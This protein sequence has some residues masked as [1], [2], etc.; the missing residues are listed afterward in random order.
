MIFIKI[1]KIQNNKM[2]FDEK[3]PDGYH[4]YAFFW[5]K[6]YRRYNAIRLT[7]I[8]KKDNTRYRQADNGHIKPIRL[9]QLDL[10][11][12]NG[13][14]KENYISDINGERLNINMGEIEINKVSGSSCKKIKEFG[15]RLY[16]RGTRVRT[17]R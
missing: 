12:D 7:H 2:Y 8:A 17:R 15:T 13:I 4:Y 10:Y 3:N 9:K 16:S 14:T 11:A 1:L 5:N 6:R